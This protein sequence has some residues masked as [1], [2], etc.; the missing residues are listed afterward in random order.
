MKRN[1]LDVNKVMSP[2]KILFA[3]IN[4]HR[5]AFSFFVVACLLFS[6]SLFQQHAKN[7]DSSLRKESIVSNNAAGYKGIYKQGGMTGLEFAPM[8]FTWSVNNTT[9][10]PVGQACAG[11][12]DCSL[13]E[14]TTS[15]EANPGPDTILM[16][17]WTYTLTNGNHANNNGGGIL[18]VGVMY[19]INTAVLDNN[20]TSQAGGVMSTGISNLTNVTVAG[21]TAGTQ[22]GGVQRLNGTVVVRNSIFANNIGVDCYNTMTVRNSLV[23]T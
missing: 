1:R 4:K 20:A 3:F 21:N 8:L 10:T 22:I 12:S 18:N 19:M 5:I 14:A 7:G 11:F 2:S 9:D 13:R 16:G 15:A 6:A 17:A 23:E